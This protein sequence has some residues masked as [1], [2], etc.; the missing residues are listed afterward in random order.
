LAL[1][2]AGQCLTEQVVRTRAVGGDKT[3]L[4]RKLSEFGRWTGKG[5]FFAPLMCAS[6]VYPFGE[7][8]F[9]KLTVRITGATVVNGANVATSVA[10]S[11]DNYRRVNRT[12]CVPALGHDAAVY[13]GNLVTPTPAPI[14]TPPPPAPPP[15]PPGPTPAPS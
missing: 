12:R 1:C 6:R 9:F 4:R 13:T 14:P 2:P 3:M 11:Y 7:R 10:A 8:V 15:V 5:S